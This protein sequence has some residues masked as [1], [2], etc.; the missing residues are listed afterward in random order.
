MC[1]KISGQSYSD[2]GKGERLKQGYMNAFA[3][4]FLTSSALKSLQ[5]AV[6]R[7][8][9]MLNAHCPTVGKAAAQR[10]NTIAKSGRCGALGHIYS[11]GANRNIYPSSPPR[12]CGKEAKQHRQKVTLRR[13]EATV[14]FSSR[15][16]HRAKRRNHEAHLDMTRRRR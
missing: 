16:H 15:G 11:C 10:H 9:D 7:V 12:C 3:A 8:N 13:A 1:A 4:T 5:R 14:P 6:G 2:K